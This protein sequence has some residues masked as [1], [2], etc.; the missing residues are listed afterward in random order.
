MG[1]GEVES[2]KEIKR[3]RDFWPFGDLE[4]SFF[5]GPKAL[6]QLDVY[7]KILTSHP[8]CSSNSIVVIRYNLRTNKELG[9]VEI[10]VNS[11]LDD[12]LYDSNPSQTSTFTHSK[13]GVIL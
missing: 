2:I 12:E 7:Y 8:Y 6:E 3:L 9:L 5:R 10:E 11:H 13:I 1:L 4:N